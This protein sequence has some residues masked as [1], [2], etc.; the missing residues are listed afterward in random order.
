MTREIPTRLTPAAMAALPLPAGRLSVQAL[1]SGDVELRYYAPRGSDEQ[2]PHAR[3]ELYFVIAGSGSF[4]RA[5]ASASFAPGDVLFAAAGEVHRFE[6]FTADFATW[7]LFYG[8][9]KTIA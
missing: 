8:P 4:V 7:V 1:D 9:D 3:D 5:G 2:T 6:D